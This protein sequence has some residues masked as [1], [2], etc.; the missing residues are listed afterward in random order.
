MVDEGIVV[1][2]VRMAPAGFLGAVK[3]R[4][5]VN[6]SHPLGDRK[7]VANKNDTALVHRAIFD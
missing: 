2:L 6:A 3:D 4:G 1:S 7:T 5:V